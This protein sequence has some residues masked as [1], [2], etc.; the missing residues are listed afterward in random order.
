MTNPDLQVPSGGVMSEDCG[1]QHARIVCV[2]RC[3]KCLAPIRGRF[4]RLVHR[5]VCGGSEW[6]AIRAR[7]CRGP[8][9]PLPGE[10]AF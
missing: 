7:M 8:L 4:E 10:E 5:R 1:P 6:G 3:E 2:H 9:G